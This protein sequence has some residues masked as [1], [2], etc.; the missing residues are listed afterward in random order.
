MRFFHSDFPS[1]LAEKEVRKATLPQ[2]LKPECKYSDYGTAEAV[3]LSKTE[4]S[5]RT[6]YFNKFLRLGKYFIDFKSLGVI[7]KEWLVDATG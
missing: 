2:R 1:G 4:Y 7:E 5:S 6:V 3:P